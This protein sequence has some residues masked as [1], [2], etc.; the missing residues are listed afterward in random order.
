MS[1]YSFPHPTLEK[2]TV[3]FGYDHV[4]GYFYDIL[5]TEDEVIEEQCSRFNNLTGI[6][7]HSKL[8]D[9]IGNDTQLRDQFIHELNSMSL[10]W[11]F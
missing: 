10:D 11:G 6:Q 2:C 9:I 3:S 4:L 8:I 5:N 1:R 7:L